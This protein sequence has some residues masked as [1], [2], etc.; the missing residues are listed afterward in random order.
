MTAVISLCCVSFGRSVAAQTRAGRDARI[1]E[2][3]RGGGVSAKIKHVAI[4]GSGIVGVSAAI[5]LQR[6]GL[7]VTLIDRHGP[8]AGA[9]YGNAG[10]LAASSIVPVPVPGLIPKLPR[11]LANP[12]EPLF[13]RWHH[14]PKALPFLWRYLRN[15]SPEA[16]SRISR[17]LELLLHDAAN[18]HHALA[19]GTGA[20]QFL[21]QGDYLYGYSDKQ[22]Y[23]SQTFAWEIRRRNGYDFDELNAEQIA[24]YDPALAG[25][26]GFAVRC[27][28]HGHITDPE[29]YVSA[30]SNHVRQQGGQ[31]ITTEIR[32]IL[33]N[34]LMETG[35][36]IL[37]MDAVI[38]AAGVWSGK[39]MRDLGMNVAMESE[40][41]YHIEFVDPSVILR[42]PVMVSSG[43][44]ALT[45][46]RGR[47]RCA[48]IV[49]FGGLRAPPSQSPHDL[50]IRQTLR[51]FPHMSYERVNSWMGHRPST[52]DS[53]PVIGQVSKEGNIWAAFGHQHV[54]LTGGPKTGRWLAQLMTGSPVNADLSPFS[55]SRFQ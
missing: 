2:A 53:L 44:F 48:G 19:E 10:V 18:Q 16:V 3:G 55:P 22:A 1:S 33:P 17:S 47:L 20:A 31:F 8:A 6:E 32:R 43:K 34:G 36:G 50:L 9:S 24:D 49:E 7:N 5:W 25:R 30:L 37:H 4:I 52:V 38:I 41:G 11:M 27:P 14:V 42:S 45:S 54:G 29:A 51:L 35:N 23:D 46:M 15:A 26:F 39:L 21:V 13:L 12:E 40:R 28:D